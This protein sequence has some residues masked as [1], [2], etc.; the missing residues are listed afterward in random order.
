MSYPVNIRVEE[1]VSLPGGINIVI[2][3]LD[4]AGNLISTNTITFVDKNHVVR[5]L[6]RILSEIQSI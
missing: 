6:N 5:E 1:S 2:E 4:H 3:I